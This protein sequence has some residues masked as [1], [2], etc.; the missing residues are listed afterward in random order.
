MDELTFEERLQAARHNKQT[1]LAQVAEATGIEERRLLALEHGDAAALPD[2]VY[3]KGAIRNYALFLDL[4]PNEMMTLY[5]TA[6]PAAV[7]V[8][9]LQTVGVHRRL[10]PLAVSTILAVVLLLV[11][12]LALFATHII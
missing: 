3:L 12:V 5:R 7:K 9:P 4:D 8:R 1:T 11:L 2:D 10:T 6:R